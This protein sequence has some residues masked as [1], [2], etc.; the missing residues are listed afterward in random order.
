MAQSQQLC[1]THIF[2]RGVYLFKVDTDDGCSRSGG[3][4]SSGTWTLQDNGVIMIE[5][6]NGKKD[7]WDVEFKDE[8]HLILNGRVP[9]TRE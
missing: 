6:D 9:M 8:D 3:G 2:P 4:S 1:L 5:F 7:Q